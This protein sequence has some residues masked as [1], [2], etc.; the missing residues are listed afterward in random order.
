L[1]EFPAKEI[2]IW[3]EILQ[4]ESEEEKN[5]K[6]INSEKNTTADEIKNFFKGKIKNG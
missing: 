1:L 4:A 6:N 5:L 3:L 2:D